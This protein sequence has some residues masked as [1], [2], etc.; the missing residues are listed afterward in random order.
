LKESG[1]WAPRGEISEAVR[2]ADDRFPLTP[3]GL[4]EPLREPTRYSFLLMVMNEV[5]NIVLFL[6]RFHPLLV[7]LPIGF[8][9]LLVGLE[10]LARL[11]RYRGANACAGYV[12]VMLVP[13]AVVSAGC[14]WLLSQSGEYEGELLRLHRWLGFATALLCG[15]VAL[16][17]WRR[18]TRAYLIFLYLS[19]VVLGLTGHFGGSLTHGSDYLAHYAP[20]LIKALMGRTGAQVDRGMPDSGSGVFVSEV[21]PI[22]QA[23]CGACHTAQR[24][25]GG[26]R[27]DSIESLIRGGE[28]GPAIVIGDAATSLLMKRLLLPLDDDGHMPPGG[29]PQPKPSEIAVLRRWIDEGARSNAVEDV[30]LRR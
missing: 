5:P 1:S 17:H 21:Q 7:H 27:V 3:K 24:R 20:S 18:W 16:C 22:L 8:L 2:R 25:K 30:N 10:S 4:V 11:R 15:L 23:R 14:G 13:A 12:L 26:L 19:A 28:D 9:V 6:G 29:K